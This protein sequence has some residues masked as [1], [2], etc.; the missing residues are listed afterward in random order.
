M[1]EGGT[2]VVP[3]HGRMTDSAD[4]AYYR[5]MVTIMRDR[6]AAMAKKG[7]TLDQIKAARPSRDYDG[8]FG[9]S[10]AWTPGQF[11]ESIYRTL[12]RSVTPKK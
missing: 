3:G 9:K 2:L 1:M 5:D 11:V 8:R 6:V 10:P 7:M 12:D 4:V